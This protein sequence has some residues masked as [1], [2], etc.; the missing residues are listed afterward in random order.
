MG[1]RS[2]VILAIDA[3]I[4]PALMVAFAKCEETQKLCTQHTDHLDTDYDGMG[5]WL[6]R[7][8]HIKWYDSYPEIEMI[9]N[10]IEAMESD[11]LDEFGIPSDDAA[12]ISS[13]MFRFVRIGEDADDNEI[14]GYG[15]EN[16][17]ISRSITY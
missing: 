12:P 16:I 7:W 11:E 1:Y 9:N 13:E 3:K 8:D 10:L 5:N 6:M 15:F 14:R 2:E 4:V 17:Y